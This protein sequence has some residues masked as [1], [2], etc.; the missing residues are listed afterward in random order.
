[1][2]P[3]N[4]CQGPQGLTGASQHGRP[5]LASG[6]RSRCQCRPNQ[7]NV[8]RTLLFNKNVELTRTFL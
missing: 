5:F 1:M 4:L 6:Q 2:G 7:G 3:V 8:S